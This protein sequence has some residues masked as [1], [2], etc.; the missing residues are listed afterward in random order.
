LSTGAPELLGQPVDVLS[1]DASTRGRVVWRRLCADRV[2]LVAIGTIALLV[3]V[4][5]FA[6]LIVKLVGARPPGAQST[7]YLTS[8]DA[9]LGPSAHN[10]F[11]ADQLGR[12]VF[13]RVLYGARVSLEVAVISTALIVAIGAVVG[14][15]A[16]Y[17]GGWV[18]TLLSRVTD[19]FLAFP[20][21]LLAI[22]LG[23]A[24]A[25]G[26]GCIPVNYRAIGWVLMALGAL[27]TAGTVV[28]ILRRGH[29][30]A[31]ALPWGVLILAGLALETVTP[32]RTGGIIQ[33]GITDVIFVIVISGWPYVARIV[34]GQTLS[35]REQ[36]F[37]EAARSIG[38]SDLRILTRH[39]LPN[40]TAALLVAGAVLIPGVVLFEAALSYLGVGV[41][42]PTASWGSM[43]S[44]ATDLF[45]SA[46]WFMLFPGL[47]LLLCVLAFNLLGDAVQDALSG[48]RRSG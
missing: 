37:V 32:P 7:R 25:S 48:R 26:S 27:A 30:L 35:L 2:A 5:V 12:D 11:G 24:C 46:W 43:I 15:V 23:A 1:G 40:L 36:Q 6:P 4:A 28:L 41:Q 39:L 18:D 3:L 20:L 16:G 42:P 9:P 45:S 22:G 31:R 29:S 34:R 33:P 38:A 44:D 13:S 14:L 8:A 19:I 21:L 47:A 10:L 17:Y